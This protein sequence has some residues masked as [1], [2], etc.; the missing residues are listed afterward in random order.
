VKGFRVLVVALGSALRIAGVIA[1]SYPP[2]ADSRQWRP[3]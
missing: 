2:P 1:L 3:A